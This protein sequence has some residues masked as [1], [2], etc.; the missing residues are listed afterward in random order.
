MLA[1]DARQAEQL[2]GPFEIE[3][4]EVLGNARALGFLA[5]AQLDIGAEP[6]ALALDGQA[7][8]GIL[9]HNAIVGPVVAF[10][11]GLGELAR[12]LA[13]GVIGAG[14][15]RA[16]AAAAQRQPAA[17][18]ALALAQ[19]A[20][21]RV[22]AVGAFG[23][24]V[25]GQ[26][27][28]EHLGHFRRLL[29]HHLFGLGLEVAPEGLEQ[30]LPV[31]APVADSVELVFEPGCVIEGDILREEAFEEGGQQPPALFGEEAVFLHPHISTV[32]QRLDRA[33]IGRGAADAEFF[34]PLDQARLGKA[35]RRLGKVLVGIDPAL[36]RA[37]ALAHRGQQ[38][39]LVVIGIVAAF[40][41]DREEAG[42][43]H[44]LPGGAQFVLAGGIAQCDSGAFELRRRHL[45]G[46]RALVH[47]IVELALVTRGNAVARKIGRADRFV[48]FL[49]VLGLRLVD[50]R[51]FGQRVATIAIGHRLAAF[52]DRAAIHL[53]AVGTHVGD[54]ARF[55]ERLRQSHRVAGGE[56]Q[57]A[58]GFLLQRRGGERG[59]GIALERLGLDLLDREIGRFDRCLGR[60]GA[61]FIAQRQLVELLALVLDQPRIEFAAV[62]LQL[63]DD[64][65]VFIG[66]EALDL[67]LAVDD[68]PQG[69][70]LHA[71]RALRTGKPPPQHRRKREAIEIVERAAREIGIDQ[72]LVELARG[73]HRL[74]HRL[75]GDRVERHAVDAVGQRLALLQQFEH[76]PRNRLALAVG[77]GRED[78]PVGALGRVADFLEALLLVAIEFPVH[79]EALVRADAAIL[80]RQVADVTVAGENL[81]VLAE[82]F[83][84][85]FRLGGRF[86]DDQLHGGVGSPLRVY[87]RIRAKM[88]IGRELRQAGDCPA[89]FA[90]A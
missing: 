32:A 48:R 16:V 78:Q 3:I 83:L 36:E 60:L 18:A 59:C 9:A 74:G 70:R 87:V 35:R 6:P 73:L 28:V 86:D 90:G 5:L 43:F 46:H 55:V 76:V 75:L 51:L 69:D 64:R 7:G 66:T 54:R 61:A 27:F 57:L 81:E 71:S 41:V 8:F 77:V 17:L 82:V 24:Q 38:T 85:G 79:R 72:R 34:E 37:V 52:R 40:L 89:P 39:V 49:R 13:V 1:D 23:E 29:V 14:D 53:H 12:E 65:P 63:G 19:R 45:A 67:D 15:E 47:Q 25:V 21:A 80:G 26:E 84:D 44:H 4:V 30:L 10:A 31:L 50:T 20:M 33:G 42:I 88:G 22:L 68:Q 62:L 11:A 56:A 2:Q 58:R